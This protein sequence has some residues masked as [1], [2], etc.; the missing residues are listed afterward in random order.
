MKIFWDG[1]IG[2]WECVDY[3]AARRTSRNRPAGTIEPKLYNINGSCYRDLILEKLL[4]A[5]SEKCPIDMK[6][7]PIFVQHDNAPPHKSVFSTLPAL[8]DKNRELG[9]TVMV[10]EQP[11]NSPDLNVLDLG[12]FR[13][14]QSCQFCNAPKDLIQLIVQTKE[15]YKKFPSCSLDDVWLTLQTCMNDIVENDGDNNYKITHMSKRKL[16]REGL[17][18]RIIVATE[19]HRVF[20]ADDGHGDEEDE[21]I[22]EGNNNDTDMTEIA[23]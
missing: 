17:L 5:I 4:P 11:A 8:V 22:N 14:L 3:V 16:E 15:T 20:H 13:A 21:E 6:A 9:I 7:K 2:I 23:V 18:P 19:M 10:R 1:K 12:V